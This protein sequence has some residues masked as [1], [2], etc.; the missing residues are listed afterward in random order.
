MLTD[1]LECGAVMAERKLGGINFPTGCTVALLAVEPEILFM[2]RLP[3]G[4]D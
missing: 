3:E 2:R 1:Q 4:Q